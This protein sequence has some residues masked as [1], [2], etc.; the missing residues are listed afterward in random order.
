MV[1]NYE[2]PRFNVGEQSAVNNATE[3]SLQRQ[4][5]TIDH[6]MTFAKALHGGG[7]E[8]V[9]LK[10]KRDGERQSASMQ[11][12]SKSGAGRRRKAG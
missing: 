12:E 11:D 9:N 5:R 1:S 6:I 7:A 8:L 10:S 2:I 4:F 3:I